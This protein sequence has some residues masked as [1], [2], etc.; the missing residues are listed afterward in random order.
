MSHS[1]RADYSNNQRPRRSVLRCAL[2]YQL[3]HAAWCV[4]C[5]EQPTGSGLGALSRAWLWLVCGHASAGLLRLGIVFHLASLRRS[6]CEVSVRRCG[7][8]IAPSRAGNEYSLAAV[9]NGRSTPKRSAGQGTLGLM[10]A[11]SW[12]LM[13]LAGTRTNALVR[14]C[15]VNAHSTRGVEH[16]HEA[17]HCE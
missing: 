17:A 4:V 10:R 1:R 11:S 6:A 2:H 8:G 16:S 3:P 7:C 5:C 13:V 14:C 15:G 12:A 9:R